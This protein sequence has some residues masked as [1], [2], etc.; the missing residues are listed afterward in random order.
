MSALSP[1]RGVTPL[2]AIEPDG[3]STELIL[4]TP[5]PIL[6]LIARLGPTVRALTTLAQLLTWSHPQAGSIAS[7][8][9]VFGWLGAC[10]FGEYIVHYGLNAIGLGA[11]GLGWLIF[12]KAR[13]AED[14]GAAEA[15]RPA[16]M[17]A[18]RVAASI[19]EARQLELA[20]LNLRTEWSPL[21]DTITWRNQEAALEATALLL[22]SYPIVLGATHFIPTNYIVA[23]LG[24][25]LLVWHS[26][27]FRLV[28][29]ALGKSLLLRFFGRLSLV[30]LGAGRG[31]GREANRGRSA[32]RL[33]TNKRGKMPADAIAKKAKS[34][35]EGEL[36]FVFTI[37]EHQRWWIGLGFTPAMLPNERPSWCVRPA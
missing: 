5:L 6:Q 4:A 36:V 14:G 24:S 3:I 2:P 7:W 11:L 27:W 20:M 1:P 29:R 32:V 10:L 35:N 12:R 33:F 30:A 34:D 8:F 21:I 31:L 19:E 15:Y 17:D 37:L 18:K 22:T 16:R 23:A 26:S 13:K 9:L 25:L 28:R